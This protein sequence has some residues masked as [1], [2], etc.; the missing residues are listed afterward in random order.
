MK[1]GTTRQA[2]C[3]PWEDA[4]GRRNRPHVMTGRTTP[5]GPYVASDLPRVLC[6]EHHGL[7]TPKRCSKMSLSCESAE[8]RLSPGGGAL[9]ELPRSMHQI[10][11]AAQS[12]LL[13]V[14][15]VH[16]HLFCWLIAAHASA[17]QTLR[18]EP[19]R[20]QQLLPTGLQRGCSQSETCLRFV[21]SSGQVLG[22]AECNTSH[23]VQPRTGPPFV[24]L[25]LPA[26]FK[27]R[28][29]RDLAMLPSNAS[30]NIAY[31]DRSPGG[32]ASAAT[33][34]QKCR[35]S[36]SHRWLCLQGLTKQGTVRHPQ[37]LSWDA[38]QSA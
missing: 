24:S 37:L 30:C 9:S 8:Q 15:L 36:A 4:A 21:L 25:P 32:D 12:S 31:C 29:K 1:P 22:G 35:D 23:I 26:C 14:T 18:T 17:L 38:F 5:G 11:S 2:G 28:G 7:P 20:L 6:A 27:K 34:A 16:Q 13:A 3:Q 19:P 33:C 10:R